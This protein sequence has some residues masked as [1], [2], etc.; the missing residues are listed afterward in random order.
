MKNKMQKIID[1]IHLP[2]FINRRRFNL[3]NIFTWKASEFKT[4]FFYL[5]VPVLKDF[6]DYKYICSVSF[7]IYGK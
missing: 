4:F 7:L 6:L 5:C 1:E 3:N 2:H